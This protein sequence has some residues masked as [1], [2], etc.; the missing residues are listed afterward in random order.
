MSNAFDRLA[1]THDE[2][3]LLHIE[4]RQIRARRVAIAKITVANNCNIQR[5]FKTWNVSKK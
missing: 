1:E 5:P 2:E 3:P 4:A